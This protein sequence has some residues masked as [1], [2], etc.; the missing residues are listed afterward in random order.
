VP[1]LAARFKRDARSHSRKKGKKAAKA[2]NLPGQR[3][4]RAQNLRFQV[5]AASAKFALSVLRTTRH[6]NTCLNFERKIAYFLPEFY[7]QSG[8]I[9]WRHEWIEFCF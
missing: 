7:A 8:A 4:E 9:F 2:S 3:F 1:V 5:E 6:C